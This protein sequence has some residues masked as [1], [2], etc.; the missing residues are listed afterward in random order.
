MYDEDTIF[1]YVGDVP[2]EYF[3]IGGAVSVLAQNATVENSNF[4]RNT[5]RL[6][7][8]LYVESDSGNTYIDNSVFR[9]CELNHYIDRLY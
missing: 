7:G 9:C 2:T 4:T 8:G 5:A 1:Y 3:G 6:G